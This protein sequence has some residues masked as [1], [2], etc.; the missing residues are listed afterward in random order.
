VKG[1]DQQV[2]EEMSSVQRVV[3][4]VTFAGISMLAGL[5]YFTVGAVALENL[6]GFDLI[7]GSSL[8][9]SV[10]GIL[11]GI[12]LCKLMDDDEAGF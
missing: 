2:T 12:I 4:I 7:A 3:V 10:V 8:A 6:S 9:S 11:F 5:G 1:Q